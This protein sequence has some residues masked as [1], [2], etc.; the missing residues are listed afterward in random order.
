MTKTFMKGQYSSNC[1][2]PNSNFL[3]TF[4]T[5]KNGR[6]CWKLIQSLERTIWV[7]PFCC[8]TSFYECLRQKEKRTF[9]GILKRTILQN[10]T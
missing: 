5:V 4:E 8:L 2:V 6:I 10:T 7:R 1:T 3:K 9:D